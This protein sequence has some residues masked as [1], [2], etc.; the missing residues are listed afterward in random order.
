MGMADTIRRHIPYYPNAP[1]NTASASST[2]TEFVA[3]F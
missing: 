2:I 1:D 3:K